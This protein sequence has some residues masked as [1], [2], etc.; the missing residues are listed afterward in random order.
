MGQM[1]L[2]F[3]RLML[4]SDLSIMAGK[5]ASQEGGI[6]HSYSKVRFCEQNNDENN[7]T[8]DLETLLQKVIFLKSRLYCMANFS[9]ENLVFYRE[10]LS[11]TL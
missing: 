3:A 10:I 5:R 9:A 8:I 7:E 6:T 11:Q 4:V 2:R 1:S